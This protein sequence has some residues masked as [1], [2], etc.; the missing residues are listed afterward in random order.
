MLRALLSHVEP[1]F[2]EFLGVVLWAIS[3][4]SRVHVL[5]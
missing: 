5:T 1:R 3:L 4:A 2:G